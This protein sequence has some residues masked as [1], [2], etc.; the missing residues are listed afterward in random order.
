MGG[1]A[2]H[3]ESISNKMNKIY[4]RLC[5]LN[6]L[7]ISDFLINDSFYIHDWF[8][9]V[10]FFKKSTQEIQLTLYNP[11]VQ[12]FISVTFLMVINMLIFKWMLMLMIF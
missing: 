4:C 1:V 3:N 11:N 6:Y 9:F 7:S 2:P 8:S 10:R 5:D 12:L